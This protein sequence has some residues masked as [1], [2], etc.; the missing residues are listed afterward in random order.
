MQ[1]VTQTQQAQDSSQAIQQ[2]LLLYGYGVFEIAISLIA[3]LI[4]MN[5]LLNQVETALE[6]L[7]DT[8]RNEIVPELKDINARIANFGKKVDHLD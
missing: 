7:I 1:H 6:K 3:V 2:P 4:G 8:V 5:I